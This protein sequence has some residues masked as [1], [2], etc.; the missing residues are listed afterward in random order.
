MSEVLAF[1]LPLLL[2]VPWFGVLGALFW[3]YPRQPAGRVRR[4]YDLATL[5]TSLLVCLLA[6]WLAFGMA[7]TESA[8]IWPQVLASLYVYAGFLAVLLI[9]WP[10]RRSVCA[11]F[12]GSRGD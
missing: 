8:P 10:L 4:I 9:A 12:G 1:Y 2:F 3:F 7:D 11:S 5:V 6:A